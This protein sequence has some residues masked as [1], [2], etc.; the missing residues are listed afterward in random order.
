MNPRHSAAMSAMAYAHEQKG[1]FKEAAAKF[2]EASVV[3]EENRHSTPYYLMEAARNL[4][5]AGDKSGALKLYETVK[6]KY[7]QSE[8]AAGDNIDKYIARLSSEDFD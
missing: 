6:N 1:E 8:A 2:E 7:P 4:E 5:A 3:P